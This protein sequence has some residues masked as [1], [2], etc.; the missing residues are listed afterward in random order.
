MQYNGMDESVV[1]HAEKEH[2]EEAGIENTKVV[3]QHVEL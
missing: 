2:P 3:L 1:A